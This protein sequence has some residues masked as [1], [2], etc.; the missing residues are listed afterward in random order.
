MVVRNAFEPDIAIVGGG[1]GGL[2]TGILL[3]RQGRKVV[4]FERSNALGGRARTTNE[5]GFFMNLG[6]H[7]LYRGGP[8]M[9]LL[10]EL[11]IEPSGNTPKVSGQF[12]IKGGVKHT[13]PSGVVSMLATGLFDL[14]AKLEAARLL[15]AVAKIQGAA[16]EDAT[17]E[18]WLDQTIS[19][20]DVRSFILAVFRLATYTNAPDKM[21]AGVTLEQLK[22]AITSNVLYIDHG[23]Q[24]I[25]D[26]LVQEAERAGVSLVSGA[27]V[28]A[29]ERDGSGAVKAVHLADGRSCQV[30]VAIVAASP[31]AAANL[32]EGG[33]RTLLKQ[34]AADSIPVKAACLDVA[35][36]QLTQPNAT[37]ALG[38]DTPLYFSVH[39]ATAR[40]SPDGAAMIQLAKYLPPGYDEP[41]SVAEAELEQ[42]LELVQPGWREV[43]AHRRYLPE[44][45]VYNAIPLA[46]RGGFRGR[47][48]PDVPDAPGLFVV[49]DWIGPEG[50][51]ADATL[52]S[53]KSA[54]ELAARYQTEGVA[55]SV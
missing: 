43:L 41:P 23:W 10:N 49:G 14:S 26:A 18:E 36:D 6:P 22:M 7:A 44:L 11:G 42:L 4:L 16:L 46:R 20:D 15:G 38:I 47:P 35:L 45:V 9:K 52:A 51:L 17:V 39:S 40:L 33:D 24:T 3:A 55:L 32:V 25:V 5:D 19:H 27:K 2:A 54:A 48:G 31:E 21:S 37:F 12:A 13:F 50:L 8:G 1:I 28:G 53:A 29:I 30:P 34:W